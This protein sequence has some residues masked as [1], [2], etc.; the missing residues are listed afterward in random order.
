MINTEQKN[1]F[2]KYAEAF[3]IPCGGMPKYLHLAQLL[4]EF[5][6]SDAGRA[7]GRFPSEP[8][9]AEIFGVSRKTVR[10]AF[11]FLESKHQICRI[12]RR[13]TVFAANVS[14]FD[15][16]S[17]VQTIGLVWP[18]IPQD[19][20]YWIP[21]QNTFQTQAETA[22]YRTRFF[23]Y[24]FD[25]HD[26]EIEQLRKSIENCCGTVYYPSIVQ[27]DEDL[28][29]S[30]PQDYPLVYFDLPPDNKNCSSV[31][32][33]H[34]L[35]G[36][37]LTRRILEL[38]FRNPGFVRTQ[39]NVPSSIQRFHGYQ[40]ALKN[41]NIVFRENNVFSVCTTFNN[42][43]FLRWIESSCI[44]SLILTSIS[45]PHNFSIFHSLLYGYLQ[46]H[47]IMTATFDYLPENLPFP[48]MFSACHP[49]IELGDALFDQ[50]RRRI[51]QPDSMH[52]KIMIAP[53]IREG[54]PS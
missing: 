6:R 23:F 9:L 20:R 48:I 36:F 14:P 4:T 12:K 1:I 29:S 21:L 11:D 24:S 42:P 44:D 8:D 46:R 26:D 15:L 38:G 31:T 47:G 54:K 13:G 10:L 17:P 16:Q 33:N 37:L 18:K 27:P 28:I 34:E 19:N 5:M 3:G 51:T 40:A 50:I 43:A 22:G 2:H 45:L 7:A 53:E 30:L 39:A 52:R 25:D 49:Q 35:G 32:T 41:Q